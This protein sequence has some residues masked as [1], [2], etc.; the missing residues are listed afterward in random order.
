MTWAGRPESPLPQR[1]QQL[2]YSHSSQDAVAEVALSHAG[3]CVVRWKTGYQRHHRFQYLRKIQTL[4]EQF[5]ENGWKE[6]AVNCVFNLTDGGAESPQTLHQ[7]QRKKSTNNRLVRPPRAHPGSLRP[8]TH[9]LVSQRT[10]DKYLLHDHVKKKNTKGPRN[11]FI[12][13]YYRNRKR[14]K[15]RQANKIVWAENRKLGKGAES[16]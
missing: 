13:D 7:G 16:T 1:K 4:E 10:P 9:T 5:R 11:A 15:H 14:R 3:A 6:R 2:G 12:S 8:F